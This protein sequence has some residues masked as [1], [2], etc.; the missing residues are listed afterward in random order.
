MESC[1]VNIEARVSLQ[2]FFDQELMKKMFDPFLLTNEN[3]QAYKN[4]KN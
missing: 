3:R 1:L 4:Q 2:Y